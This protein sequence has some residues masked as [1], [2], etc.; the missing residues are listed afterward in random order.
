MDH[1]TK[2]LNPKL[3]HLI[4]KKNNNNLQPFTS[5]KQ[6]I[7]MEKSLHFDLT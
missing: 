2:I 1:D 7:G 5:T 6:N 3:L 4:I